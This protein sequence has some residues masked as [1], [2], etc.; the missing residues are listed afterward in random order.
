MK[1]S[2]C[3][4]FLLVLLTAR[5]WKNEPV[6]F[7]YIVYSE[8][9]PEKIDPFNNQVNSNQYI[10]SQLYY[11]L[12]E[13]VSDQDE[14]LQSRFLDTRNLYLRTHP[15]L[16]K[17]CLK[18]GIR[19]SDDSEITIHDLKNSLLRIKLAQPENIKFTILSTD[20]ECIDLMISE[21]PRNFLNKFTGV[22]TT[23]VKSGEASFPVGLGPFKFENRSNNELKLI[24]G[25]GSRSQINRIEFRAISNLKNNIK[26]EER[27]I[28]DVNHVFTVDK[29]VPLMNSQDVSWSIK[30]T[31]VLG[32]FHKDFD[33]R[34]SL[35]SCLRKENLNSLVSTK[36]GKIPGFLPTGMMGWDVDLEE[37]MRVTPATACKKL[38]NKSI[39]LYVYTP[40]MLNAY[41]K[42]SD[43]FY[44]RTGFRFQIK[45]KTL[46]ET[47]EA[48]FSGKEFSSVIGFDTSGSINSTHQE[49]AVFFE[50]FY[51]KPW[52]GPHPID[53]LENLISKAASEVYGKSK[54]EQYKL[55]HKLFLK[56]RYVFPIGEVIK[57]QSY[58]CRLKEFKFQDDISGTLRLEDVRV[59]DSCG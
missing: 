40:E 37:T 14:D 53:G 35:I 18:P 57:T 48:G 50:S 24:K 15:E 34:D 16:I 27:D 52:L 54:T 46:K 28:L 12:L 21:A 47:I 11:P 36:L 8:F 43:I 4:I 10:I 42:F 7:R 45:E 29:N 25:P 58:D 22:S 39:E 51:R 49:S 32:I 30:K 5:Y 20:T 19:F 23:I 13:L 44:N 9:I 33:F 55:A 31:Y 38:H 41:V 3:L 6:G 26:Y 17:F 2:F 1:V 59:E 56:A